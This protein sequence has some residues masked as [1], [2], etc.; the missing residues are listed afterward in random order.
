MKDDHGSLEQQGVKTGSTIHV[1][2]KQITKDSPE[3]P[4]TDEQIQKAVLSYHSAL[5]DIAGSSLAVS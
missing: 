5:G 4:I 1:F 2:S 3:E